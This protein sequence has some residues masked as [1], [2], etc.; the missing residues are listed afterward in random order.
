MKIK[1]YLTGG[2]ATFTVDPPDSDFQD[3]YLAALVDTLKYLEEQEK[4]ADVSDP[5]QFTLGV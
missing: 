1:N 3:G 2:I 5:N 4:L